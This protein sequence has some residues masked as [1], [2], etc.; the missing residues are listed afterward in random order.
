MGQK[1]EE[2]FN[3]T[4]REMQIIENNE[5]PLYTHDRGKIRKSDDSD[6]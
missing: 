3:L 6:G 5:L 4:I 2:V 1:Y